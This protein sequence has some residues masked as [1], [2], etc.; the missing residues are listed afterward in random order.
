MAYAF[1]QWVGAY[2]F[3]AFF[4]IWKEVHMKLLTS[5]GFA[6]AIV[7]I[8][9]FVAQ[10]IWAEDRSPSGLSPSKI[11]MGE[12]AQV[13]GEF[14]MAKGPEG[15]VTLD[16]VDKSYVITSQTGKEVRLELDDHTKIQNRV[17]PGD[18]VEAKISSRGHTL[19]VTRLDR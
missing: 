2:H 10:G 9:F 6:L 16:I 14:H 8:G 11:V 12:V 13:Q 1:N 17:N 5:T 19:S 3:L 15:D 18:K 7:G 4:S